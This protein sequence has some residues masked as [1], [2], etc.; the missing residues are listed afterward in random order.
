MSEKKAI[1]QTPAEQAVDCA[2]QTR[3]G[4]IPKPKRDEYHETSPAYAYLSAWIRAAESAILKAMKES[5]AYLKY[6]QLLP[7]IAELPRVF[8]NH[9]FPM[10]NYMTGVQADISSLNTEPLSEETLQ[11]LNNLGLTDLSRINND[12][13]EEE[14]YYLQ[15]IDPDA[16]YE[17]K[18]RPEVVLL[19]YYFEL[20]EGIVYH[21][22]WLGN[23]Q[24][25]IEV[26]AFYKESDMKIID[27]VILSLGEDS[28]DITWLESIKTDC[29]IGESKIADSFMAR[30]VPSYIW[31]RDSFV[32]D[33]LKSYLLTQNVSELEYALDINRLLHKELKKT[34][35]YQKEERL[36][37]K[38]LSALLNEP[39]DN[40]KVTLTI[41]KNHISDEQDVDYKANKV[42][43]SYEG[44]PNTDIKNLDVYELTDETRKLLLNLAVNYSDPI[45]VETLL[46]QAASSVTSELNKMYKAMFGIDDKTRNQFINKKK[47]ILNVKLKQG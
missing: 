17:I 32:F 35:D 34:A 16:F 3:G 31:Y 27:D 37:F 46:K 24:Q 25:Y 14:T 15:D 26:Y 12:D 19:K 47:G 45:L 21:G 9:Y 20:L 13:V 8:L 36:Q 28:D 29:Q 44:I 41:T 2:Q 23:A 30:A 6:A 4:Q 18:E 5:D 1:P 38:W 22:A 33:R 43:I 7:E 40:D 42:K 39:V 10:A 11:A